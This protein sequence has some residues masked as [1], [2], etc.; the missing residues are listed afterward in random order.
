MPVIREHIRLH[1]QKCAT[2]IRNIHAVQ[3]AAFRNCLSADMLLQCDWEIRSG[4]DAAVIAENHYPVAVDFA[5]SR[6]QTRARHI[7]HAVR[8]IHPESGNC[9]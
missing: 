4:F 3:A 7:I 1:G 6:N 2:G 5:K 9:G 8:I